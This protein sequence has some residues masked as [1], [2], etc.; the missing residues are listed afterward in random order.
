MLARKREQVE[1]EEG[2]R[3]FRVDVGERVRRGDAAEV[4][5][6]VDDGREEIGGRDDRAIVVEAVDGGVVAAG[7]TD[8]DVR[9]VEGDQMTQ[10]LRQLGAPE[11][12]GSAGAV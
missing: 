10:D 11:L 8:E 9:I 5:R 2:T 1:R 3:A 6:V 4:V 12:A 7:E